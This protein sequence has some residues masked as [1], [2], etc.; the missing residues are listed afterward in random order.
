LTDIPQCGTIITGLKI[1][2]TGK[3]ARGTIMKRFLAAGVVIVG[4]V[5]L[6]LGI[7]FIVQ[8]NTTSAEIRAGLQDEKVTLGLPVEGEEGYI[9]GNVVDTTA[10]LKA[11]QDI[12]LEH[13]RDSYGTYGDTGRDSPERTSYLDGLTLMNSMYIATMGYGV[14]T[15]ITAIGVFMI[16]VGIALGA[17][18]VLLLRAQTRVS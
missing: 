14:T 12:L 9:E 13:L 17:T 18:G 10:E 4:V 8:A 1:K 11:A 2:R 16:I 5:S 15:V 7:V 3:E 6:V